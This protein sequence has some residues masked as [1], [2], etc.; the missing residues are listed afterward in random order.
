MKLRDRIAEKYM[1]LTRS[2]KKVA[3]YTLNNPQD[4]AIHSAAEI[5]ERVGVSE[6]TIIRFCYAL[7]YSG[8]SELQKEVRRQMILDSEGNPNQSSLKKYQS[9]KEEMA[10]Q[11]RFYA[12][13]MERDIINIQRTISQIKED[14]FQLAVQKMAEASTILVSGYRTSFAAA[15]WLTFALNIIRGNARTYRPATDDLILFVEQMGPESVFIAVSFHRYMK[16]TLQ[17]ARIARERGAFVIGLT[18]TSISPIT[19]YADV[20]FAVGQG[21]GGNASTLDLSASLFSLM[22]ALVAAVS[23]SDPDRFHSR[24][25]L[26]DQ[27]ELTDF[28]T[29]HD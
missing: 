21:S 10:S 22:N 9:S 1:E 3:E 18:D 17:L 16:D 8:F 7:G 5:G 24:A 29:T 27:L 15:H 2:L 4:F 13:V 14:Q 6:T 11:S 26:Y 12:Q 20:T 25:E 19:R 28:F 23:V